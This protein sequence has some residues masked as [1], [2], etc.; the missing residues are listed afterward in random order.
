MVKLYMQKFQ[1]D[2]IKISSKQSVKDT[3]T[4]SFQQGN[5]CPKLLIKTIDYYAACSA[6][7]IHLKH[8]RH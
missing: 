6:E 2:R 8:I 5:I 7:N 1:S 3:G 4:T